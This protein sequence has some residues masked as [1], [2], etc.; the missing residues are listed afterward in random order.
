MET[1]L[2]DEDPATWAGVF[3]DGKASDDWPDK[4]FWP[5]RRKIFMVMARWWRGGGGF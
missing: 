4:L 2:F 3:E 1:A 5:F